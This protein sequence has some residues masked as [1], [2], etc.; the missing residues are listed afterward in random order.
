VQ[1]TPVR[2]RAFR[3]TVAR[4]G[5]AGLA[6]WAGAAAA[7]PP[8]VTDDPEPTDLGHWEIYAF[9]GGTSVEHGYEGGVGVDLNYGLVKDVQI[10]ATLPLEV[11][12]SGGAA[13][14]G[15][16]AAAGDVEIGVK[17]RFLHG[18]GLDVAAFPRVILPTAGKGFGSGRVALLLPVWA[19]RD[20]GPWSLFGGGGYTI[21]PGAGNRDFWQSG[22]ALTRTVSPRLS[23]G[24][25]A[26]WQEADAIGGHS[27]T[28]V[29]L[30]GIVKLGGPFSLL[31]SGG[32]VWQHHVRQ[33]Q[34][35]AYAALGLA[36]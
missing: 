33:T 1:P 26:T 22:A 27:E 7:G 9:A 34:Y 23:L 19:Q 15:T 36:F 11:A 6:W 29:G 32:P 8:Y 14:P 2:K 13:G 30:G 20:F 35:R 3:R 12:H 25:E 4:I 10:T 16:R 24:G 31:V 17:Y 28:S 18:A 21:N 5:A